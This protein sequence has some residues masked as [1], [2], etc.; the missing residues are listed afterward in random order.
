ML[1]PCN[2]LTDGYSSKKVR[3]YQGAIPQPTAKMVV[4]CRYP[5]L[6]LQ[7][8]SA[9]ARKKIMLYLSAWSC[10]VRTLLYQTT[11]GHRGQRWGR[12]AWAPLPA[13]LHFDLPVRQLLNTEIKTKNENYHSK[14]LLSPFDRARHSGGIRRNYRDSLVAACVTDTSATSRI[15]AS[16][17]WTLITAL[18]PTCPTRRCSRSSLQ[19]PVKIGTPSMRPS[20]NSRLSR[21]GAFMLII[22]S[23]SVKNLQGRGRGDQQGLLNLKQFEKFSVKEVLCPKIRLIDKRV[24]LPLTT[25]Y[26]V[27]RIQPPRKQR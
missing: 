12:L 26:T 19:R 17:P 16:V 10:A 15:M 22:F 5:C 4:F 27:F 9:S 7:Q 20:S 8:K 1:L 24:P 14:Q 25:E 13:I 3:P 2:K 6:A 11:S 18:R 21:P 23:A